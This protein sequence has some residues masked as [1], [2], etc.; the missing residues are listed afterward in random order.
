VHLELL[1]PL[2]AVLAA[3]LISLF[4]ISRQL[5]WY[6]LLWTAL[7]AVIFYFIWRFDWR[8]LI[9]Y[10]WAISGIYGFSLLLLLLTL[11]LAPS[12]RGAKSWIPIGPFKFQTSELMKAALILIYARFFSRG[13]VRIAHGKTLLAS[14]F[15]MAL[16]A[17]LI[18]LQ[19]DLGSAIILFLIWLGFVLV[20]GIRFKHIII[21]MLC[22]AVFFVLLWN[23][24][25]LDYQKAR[26]VGLF[27]PERDPFGINYSVIQSKIAIG[28]AG[29]F[30]KGFGQGTQVQL[31]FLPE[32]PT[33]FIF[34]AFVEEWGFLG[35]IFILSAFFA[36]LFAILRIG[37]LAEKNFEKFV[38][39]GAV[40]MFASQFTI[41]VG[42]S[43]GLLPVIGVPF[44]F[45]SYGG[46]NLLTSLLIVAII[47]FIAVRR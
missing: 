30:G 27:Y 35:G 9:N 25:L 15:L 37:M 5:F 20:S 10:R 6:Q 47:N 32:A 28:S 18:A 26:I 7:G 36:F 17:F 4:S 44:P 3:G 8:A 1:L 42:S 45:L 38:C 22:F 41:N 43:L 19:P 23:F 31:G 14:F 13:H 2:S 39:L 16:P 29:F 11:A 33:D 40:I 46:S 12:I 21:A 24:W 34:P